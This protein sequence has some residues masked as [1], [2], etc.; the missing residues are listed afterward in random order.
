MTPKTQADRIALAALFAGAVAIAFGPIF[1]RVSELQPTATAFYR[2]AFAVP[3]LWVWLGASRRRDGRRGRSVRRPSRPADYAKLGLAGLFFAADMGFWHWSIAYTSVANATLLANTAPVFVVLGG[4][5]IFGR[6]FGPVFLLGMAMAMAGTAVLMQTSL[7]LDARHLT[8]DIFGVVTGVFYGS[9]LLTVERLRAEF[10]T[11]TIMSH[12]IP[13][14]AV[15]ILVVSVITGESLIAITLHG[16]AVLI[17]LAL[18]SQVCGQSLIAYGLAQLPVAFASV[19]LLIQPVLSA[20][21][22]WALLDERVSARQGAG[23]IVVLAGIWVARRGSV[24][25]EAAGLT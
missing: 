22:A 16:W 8:G 21:F 13:V 23:A 11:A 1:V 20:L 7:S 12:A 10:S 25:R 2:F 24:R 17:G 4:W 14:S 3:V 19:I 5:L 9:Y 18:V 6:R 15:A